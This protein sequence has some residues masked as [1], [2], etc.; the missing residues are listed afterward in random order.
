M[1]FK[2]KKKIKT[3]KTKEQNEPKKIKMMLYP[4]WKAKQKV[5]V[6]DSPVKLDYCGD[7]YL[8]LP[9]IL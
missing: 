5:L 7:S 1:N 6:N 9:S 8:L 4:H 2:I 3:F